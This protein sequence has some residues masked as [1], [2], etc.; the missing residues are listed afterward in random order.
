[1]HQVEVELQAEELR[2]SRA[3]LESALQRQ[4]QLY[5][6]MPVG[7]FTVDLVGTMHELNLPG[8]ALLASERDALVGQSLCSFLTAESAQLLRLQLTRVSVGRGAQTC[9]LQLNRRH[10]D[11]HVVHAAFNVDPAGRTFLVALMDA[12]LGGQARGAEPGSSQAT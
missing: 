5:D 4:V 8:A 1:M 6:A 12:G 7:C 3:E 2:A 9:S 11:P 10:G